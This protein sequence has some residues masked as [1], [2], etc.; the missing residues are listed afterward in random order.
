MIIWDAI[1][2]GQSQHGAARCCV[3]IPSRQAQYFLAQAKVAQAVVLACPADSPLVAALLASGQ[4][5]AAAVPAAG[6]EEEA[7]LPTRPV[8]AW[9]EGLAVWVVTTVAMSGTR[10]QAAPN[11]KE[12]LPPTLGQL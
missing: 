11:P 1:R 7:A 12:V 8:L 6:P 10:A 5:W 4:A 9:E 2:H 3:P